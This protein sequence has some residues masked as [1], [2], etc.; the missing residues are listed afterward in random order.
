[1]PPPAPPKKGVKE[2]EPLTIL[3]I[4]D[5]SVMRNI[6]RL[7]LEMSGYRVFEAEGA[8]ES[9]QLLESLPTNL[10]FCDIMMPGMDGF[11]LVRKI[12]ELP[13]HQKTPIVM[14]TAKGTREDVVEAIQAGANDYVIKPFTRDLIVAKAVKFIGQP[15]VGAAKAARLR[16]AAREKAAKEKEKQK[17]KEGKAAAAKPAP[18]KPA[19]E[20]PPA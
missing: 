17:A 20:K 18:E 2:P 12:R 11:T 3:V 5:K 6:M 1:M 19:E 14:V 9:L 15:D 8:N 7:H 10:I 16:A 13:V 4:D